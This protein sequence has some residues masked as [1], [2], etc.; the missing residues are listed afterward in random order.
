MA[1]RK[2]SDIKRAAQAFVQEWQGRGKERQDDKT[3]W[4]DLLEDVLG[5]PR[6]RKEI[7]VQRPVKFGGT[8][9]SIDVYVKTSKVVIEQ[10]S[11]GVNLDLKEEQS[12]GAWLTPMEQGIRYFEKMD[13]PDTGRYVIACNFAEFR[14]WDSYHKNAPQR[15]IPLDQLPRRWRE[16]RFLIEPYGMERP[17]DERREEKVA[18]TASE[19]ISMVYDRLLRLTPHPTPA[20]LQSLN[21][22]CVRLVFCLYAEDAGIFDDGQFS[23]FL[24]KYPA[25]ELSEKFDTLF[26]WLDTNEKKRLS[27][28]YRLVDKTIRAFPYVNGGLFHQADAYKT[29]AIDG[30]V[31]LHLLQAW[32]LKLKDT[33]ENFSWEEISPTNFG[34]IFE[35]TVASDVRDSGGM[36]Y[37]TPANIH[38]LIGPLFLDS[39]AEE[40][41]QILPLPISTKAE[42]EL[43]Y[44]RL[45]RFRDQL[46]S[47]RFLDPACG[48]G[49]FLTETY[50]ALHEL[51]L[52]AIESEIEFQHET[53]IE[54]TDPCKVHMGQFFGI[55]VDHF[56]ASV[57]R[58]SLWIAECQLMRKTEEVLHCS[59]NLLP[60][61]TN[62]NIRCA[63]ALSTDWNDVLRRK[64]GA[65]IYIIGNPP[66]K[67]ARGGSDSKEEK[68]RKKAA[69]RTVMGDTDHSGKPV[70]DN[71]GDLDFVCAWYAKAAQYM[72]GYPR[73]RAAL[74]STNSIVQGE[75]AALLWKP[76]M[77]HY[78]LHIDFA[79]RTFRWFNK[80]KK[81]AQVHCVI[82]GFHCNKRKPDDP[83]HIYQEDGETISC[84][85]INNYLMPAESYFIN[86]E[87]KTPLCDVPKIGMGNQPIDDGNYLFT[88]EEKDD[89]IRKEPQSA[90]FFHPWYGAKEFISGIP[91]YCL[92]LG[93][94]EPNVL[95]KMP[96]CK[97]RIEAVRKYR[98]LSQRVQTRN[99]ADK[100]TRF[101]TENMPEGDYLVIPEVSS[102]RRKYV[103]I[104]YMTPN[105]LC[106]NLVRLMPNVTPYHFGILES[107]IH[108]AWMRMVCGRMKSD[109]RYSIEVVYNNFPWPSLS[110]TSSPALYQRIEQTARHILEVRERHDGST[111]RQL[112]DPDLMP[113]DL[114]DAHR[115]NDRAVFAAYE[116][117]GLRPDMGDEEIALR[118]LRESVRLVSQGKKHQSK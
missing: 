27:P 54:T 72:Q 25:N 35:S 31:R 110:A 51:E 66:F 59:L 61:E 114:L 32:H 41:S 76:L 18:T 24:E 44:T 89:F 83:C 26:L 56:A 101:G 2:A 15:I 48:S 79:W 75:H 69:M 81:M 109:Y 96:L 112:Y 104:G 87:L 98:L 52:K 19:Y 39:L 80:A 40:L 85:Q 77:T 105:I 117:I 17:V 108:M 21:M 38:R 93:D 3:F 82:I 74:V 91:R 113:A 99:I 36:H 90:A 13:K 23:T 9:K 64:P 6:S 16:L 92:W 78:H 33:G 47:L 42:K 12:D 5:I 45:E 49:N 43:K 102:E 53:K 28:A 70:W 116:P 11:H 106:S 14:I 55:E 68:E 37:T 65:T 97:K 22:F 118:L 20:E 30:V 84:K 4:E 34:C 88:E 1:T 46:A 7:E 57:A 67:G 86:P 58:T 95:D 63:D 60:L 71:V 107:S 73:I 10:K 111:L 50:K 62:N 8:T 103:P 115:A 100:P 94:C 29:P